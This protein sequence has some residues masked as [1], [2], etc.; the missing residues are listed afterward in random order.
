[1]KGSSVRRVGGGLS[2]S[3]KNKKKPGRAKTPVRK[4]AKKKV[5]PVAVMA[6]CHF[7]KKD[8]DKADM[9]C[10]GCKTIICNE[11]DVSM[12]GFGHGHPPEDHLIDPFNQ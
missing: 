12:G 2:T 8:C 1:M 5:A 11:C 3:H 6:P 4:P 7:C 9:F 10:Y